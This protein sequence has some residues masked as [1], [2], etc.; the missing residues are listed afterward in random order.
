M[1]TA[2]VVYMT[3]PLAFDH[4]GGQTLGERFVK[5]LLEVR[6]INTVWIVLSKDAPGDPRYWVDDLGCLV[7]QQLS[8]GWDAEP[9]LTDQ[10]CADA[11][12]HCL[13][14]ETEPPLTMVACVPYMPFLTSGAIELCVRKLG[15]YLWAGP[16][17]AW[18]AV[19][20]NAKGGSRR[21]TV[22]SYLG[23][24]R[25]FKA[26]LRQDGKPWDNTFGGVGLDAV[27]ALN[28]IRP[29]DRKLADALLAG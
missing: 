11:F 22:V 21:V 13:D 12:G 4:F 26:V 17:Q 19:I 2:A 20:P 24:I 29:A 10:M 7:K 3:H 1:K 14:G 28:V 8:V 18:P 25:A 15:N 16:S 5:T 23:G 27:E 9:D 6:N